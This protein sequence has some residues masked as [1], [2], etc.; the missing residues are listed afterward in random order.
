MDAPSARP[1]SPSPPEDLDLYCLECGYNLR[2]HSGD[3]RRCPECFHLNSVGDAE[4]SAEMISRLSCLGKAGWTGAL[5][6]YHL[7]ARD[8]IRRQ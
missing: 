8:R 5:A 4:L 3:P 1:G 7:L 2:G 6:R